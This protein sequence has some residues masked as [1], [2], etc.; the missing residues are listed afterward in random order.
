[1]ETFE[2]TGIVPDQ[3]TGTEILAEASTTF[4]DEQQAKAFYPIAKQRLLTVKNWHK[5]A[6]ALT[7]HF[8][9]MDT[10]GNPVDRAVEKGDLM[11]VDIP[12]PG[13]KAGDGYDWVSI[14][15]L[16]ETNE[17]DLQSV[18]FRVRP[19]ANPAGDPEKIAHFYAEDSTSNFIVSR[20]GNTIKADVVDR[21]IKPNTNTGSLLDT[22]RNTPVALGAIGL[23]S[24]VQWQSL[25][26]GLV[27]VSKTD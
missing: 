17:G 15:E 1:M 18:G 6:G 4:K 10:K 19:T 20:I 2:Y 27:D 21:N 14:E 24:K 5:I 13:N 11:R 25:A 3:H 26:D 7:A 8:Q 12:G 9:A 22:I 23:F 16:N